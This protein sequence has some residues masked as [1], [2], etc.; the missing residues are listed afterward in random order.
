MW[1]TF[2]G[3]RVRVGVRGLEGP[4][5]SGNSR[6]AGGACGCGAWVMKYGCLW[7]T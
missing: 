5:P 4:L 1:L 7:L 2:K 3:L 6:L